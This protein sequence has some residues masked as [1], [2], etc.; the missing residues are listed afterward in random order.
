MGS[1]LSRWHSREVGAIAIKWR[2][3]LHPCLQ[4]GS[5]W[6]RVPSVPRRTRQD[7]RVGSPYTLCGARRRNPRGLHPTTALGMGEGSHLGSSWG[8]W[9]TRLPSVLACES[10]ISKLCPK[11][12]KMRPGQDGVRLTPPKGWQSYNKFSKDQRI[13]KNNDSELEKN[14]HEDQGG[15]IQSCHGLHDTSPKHG[16]I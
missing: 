8:G 3:A 13:T 15:G 10:Q 9:C 7:P 5:C 1:D 4:W 14:Q 11:V 6:R 2:T 16:G 12:S